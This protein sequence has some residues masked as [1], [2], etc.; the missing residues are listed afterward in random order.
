MKV[1]HLEGMRVAIENNWTNR[2]KRQMVKKAK[3]IYMK[4]KTIYS[5]INVTPWAGHT[6]YRPLNG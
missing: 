6:P 4:K 5:V 3:K 1:Q 2:G